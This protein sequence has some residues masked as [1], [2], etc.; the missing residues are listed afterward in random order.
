MPTIYRID[1]SFLAKESYLQIAVMILSVYNSKTVTF[2]I[3]YFFL[4]VAYDKL[5]GLNLGC[6]LVL[7][8]MNMP[9]SL[10]LKRDLL[11]IIDE[12][13]NTPLKYY[14]LINS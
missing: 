9:R 10:Q 5:F 12:Q 3:N 14:I 2:Q 13:L 4:P 7:H 1:V 6:I 8:I 11:K